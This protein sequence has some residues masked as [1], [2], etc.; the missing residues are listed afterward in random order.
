MKKIK[1]I[2]YDE[3]YLYT[4]DECMEF[5][6]TPIQIGSMLS[7]MIHSLVGR[8]YVTKD[9]IN[10]AVEFALLDDDKLEERTTEAISNLLNNVAEAIKEEKP[11]KKAKPKKTTKK[12]GNK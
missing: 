12:E 3:C 10:S 4:T 6:A 7:A 9:I 11:K 8:G 1:M 5:N 2:K